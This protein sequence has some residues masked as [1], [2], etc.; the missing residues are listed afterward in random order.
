[1][2]GLV[3]VVG[4]AVVDSLTGPCRLLVAR[5]TAPPQFAGM[6]EFPG[7]KV[8]P[9]ET[10]EQALHRELLEELG[11]SILLGT[12]LDSGSA[13]GWPLNAR[14][15]MRVWLAEV[16]DGVPHPLQDHDELRWIDI[17]DRDEVLGLPW[18]PADLPIVGALLDRLP[19]AETGQGIRPGP[20]E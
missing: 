4:G 15:R 10:A 1:M 13:E 12:E 16:R 18:I 2:N 9:G 3:Q 5:R 19:A 17:R 11:V 14:A 8:E 20:K 6:W 7:G